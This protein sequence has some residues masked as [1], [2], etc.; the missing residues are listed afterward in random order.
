MRKR[1]TLFGLALVFLVTGIA[2]ASSSEQS[3]SPDEA[4]QRLMDGNK[5]YVESK[6][7]SSASCNAT[8]RAALAS[9]QKPY[10]IILTCS[11]SRVPP[12]IIFDKGLG[13]IFVIRVAG[14]VPDPVVIGSIEYAAEHLGS[15]LV[16][17]LGHE[18]CGAVKATVEAKGKTTG[19]KNID[20]IAKA[21]E[22]SVKSA[23]KNCKAGKGNAKCADAKNSE[24][25]EN[26]SDANAK[27]VAANLT[28]Q[29]PILKHLAKEKKIKIVAA[30]YDL[31]DG[32]VTLFK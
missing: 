3:I 30:K 32:L 6:M 26:V 4:L 14:N 5:R 21:I 18:R 13:E 8:S 20:A 29:S 2:L 16:M 7:T 12:E 17:V 15:P 22:P 24:F 25:L 31:D 27:S 28:K 11:D 9:S 10:A 19:S 23:A 1:I